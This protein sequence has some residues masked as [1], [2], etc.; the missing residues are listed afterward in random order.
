M[1]KKELREA[2]ENGGI[3][4]DLFQFREGQECE[5]Y[6]AP[7]FKA[8][9]EILYIPDID[10]NMIQTGKASVCE[11]ELSN[12]I[13]C[14]YTGDDFIDECDGNTELAERLF[15]YCDWQHPSSALSELDDEQNDERG[16][17]KARELSGDVYRIKTTIGGMLVEVPCD[18]DGFTALV[19][20]CAAYALDGN[21]ITQVSRISSYTT[22]T[23][24]VS[25]LGR[26]EYKA[27]LK[28]LRAE[29]RKMSKRL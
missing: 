9:S 8:G 25:V 29:Q 14:C 12:I 24:R 4:D 27:E 21:I 2:L 5:I 17:V 22:A 16:A 3:M 23:P 19:R 20:F 7:E 6:K 10:L 11:E 28:R 1:T 15:N 26:E 18:P 13:D